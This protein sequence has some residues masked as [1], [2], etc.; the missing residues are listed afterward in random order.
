MRGAIIYFSGTGNTEFVAKQLKR[1]LEER[2]D[3]CSLIDI[4]KKRGLQDNYDFLIFGSPI[5]DEAFPNIF[6]EWVEVNVKEGR[7]REVI[8]F[9]TLA[10][11]NAFGLEALS[12]ILKDKGFNIKIQYA[13]EMPNNYYLSGFEK[14]SRES[15]IS[16]REKAKIEVEHLVE[17]FI[18]GETI[19]ECVSK[20]SA[21]MVKE[22]NNVVF[23]TFKEWA[24]RYLSVDMDIC[25]RCGKCVKNCPT[26]NISLKDNFIFRDRCTCCL[27]CLHSCPVNAFL[28]DGRKIEQYKI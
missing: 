9:S 18:N 2:N 13:V 6:M 8:V 10:S 7:N 14:P 25:V 23:T 11:K 24:N 16:M 27:R 21:Q 26:R 20:T 3:K 17:K 15:I 28:F 1:S 12:K 22:A 5:H 4:A 19:I